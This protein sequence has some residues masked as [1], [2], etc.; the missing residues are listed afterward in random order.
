MKLQGTYE[1]PIIIMLL[2]M[3]FEAMLAGDF[4]PDFPTSKGFWK[5][6]NI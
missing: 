6:R 3:Y 2:V 4:K 1:L 5:I